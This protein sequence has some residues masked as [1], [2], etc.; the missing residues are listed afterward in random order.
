M[1]GQRCLE[2]LKGAFSNSRRNIY[3]AGAVVNTVHLLCIGTDYKQRL[4]LIFWRNISPKIAT[5]CPIVVCGTFEP[6]E[7]GLRGIYGNYEIHRSTDIEWKPIQKYLELVLPARKDSKGKWNRLMHYTAHM[8]NYISLLSLSPVLSYINSK[9]WF[10]I[11]LSAQ[12]I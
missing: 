10:L 1:P 2:S 12:H 11:E 7:R 8:Y 9:I 6:K 3:L 5:I 4:L